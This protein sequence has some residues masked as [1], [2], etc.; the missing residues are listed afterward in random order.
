MRIYRK[1]SAG[2]YEYAIYHYLWFWLLV[3]IAVVLGCSFLL[4]YIHFDLL[5]Y[6]R[7]V[8]LLASIILFL[9]EAV[10]VVT[11]SMKNGSF[12]KYCD[13][14]FLAYSVRKAL[15]NT[16]TLNLY[17]DSPEIEMP[18]VE[19]TFVH[20]GISV[21]VDKL[22]GMTDVNRVKE[23]ISSSFR[24]RYQYYAVTE[25]IEKDDETGFEFLLTN[26]GENKTFI[27]KSI[28]DLVQ[29]PYVFKLQ[30]GLEINFARAPHLS[31]Y[32]ATGS[33][34]STVL[35]SMIAQCL[36]N[37]TDLYFI[38]KKFEFSSLAVFY[39]KSKIAM[40]NADILKVL[41]HV[42]DDVLVERQEKVAAEV[43]KRRKMGLTGY[44]LGLKPVVIFGDEIGS[45]VASMDSKQK[46]QFLNY[47]IQIIQKGRSVSIF[48]I[49]ASQSPATDVLPSSIRS[50]FSTRILL[51]SASADFQR[52]AFDMVATD[53]DVPRFQGYYMESGKTKQPQRFFVPN[54]F[55]HNL[56]TVETFEKL[57]N[58]DF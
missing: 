49:V 29:K 52:M 14:L 45:V 31:C 21:Y 36:S 13:S 53:S 40:T 26:V 30:E 43:K 22:A 57:Y 38:D 23:N 17:K 25:A 11:G 7:S 42:V 33:G 47:L 1:N 20:D 55:K 54:L 12:L 19:V 50:Q 46:K 48:L 32:G 18:T 56:E 41:Q 51:G 3:S 27:P 10:R 8:G 15:L 37:G 28:S 34:K 16:M 58:H 2:Y 39:P 24:G 9:I 5:N 4:R 35:L 44:D 6:L